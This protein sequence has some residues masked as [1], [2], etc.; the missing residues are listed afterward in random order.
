MKIG[1]TGT[2][3][4]MTEKQKHEIAKLIKQASEF[5]HG[6]CIGADSE[7]HQLAIEYGIFT[8]IHPPDNPSKRA[9]CVGDQVLPAKPYLDRNHDIVDQTEVLIA[10]PFEDEDKLR[11][12]TWATIRYAK[13]QGVPIRM[14]TRS[15][16]VRGSLVWR[17]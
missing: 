13:R 12:G 11:S 15:G 1:F 10:A 6:D 17:I 14:V 5:H 2:Q 16:I 7:A 3:Q 9:W 4:G 8:V